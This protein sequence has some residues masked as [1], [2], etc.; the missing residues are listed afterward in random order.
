MDTIE[1][2]ARD[3]INSRIIMLKNIHNTLLA[4]AFLPMLA[5]PTLGLNMFSGNFDFSNPVLV[6][7]AK[8]NIISESRQLQAA[9]LDKYFTERKMPLAGL[10][11]HFV[12]V[13]E[14]Y[15]LPYNFLPAISAIESSGGKAAYNNN[16]FG[17]GSAKIYFQNFREAIEVVG[18][19]LGGA[20][21]NTAKYYADHTLEQKLWYYNESV[22]PGYTQQVFAAMKKIENTNLD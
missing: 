21:F 19:N 9:K 6:T 2:Q 13:A 20:N 8:V 1:K 14:K 5:M 10:G 17:W 3:Q 12:L 16:P 18:Q 15:G 22:V 4:V 11:M 7:L